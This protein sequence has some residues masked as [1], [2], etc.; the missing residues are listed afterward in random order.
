M[1]TKSDDIE[2]PPWA[3]RQWGSYE[4]DWLDCP[5]CLELYEKWLEEGHESESIPC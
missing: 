4:H 1:Q 2:L 5:E 3:C